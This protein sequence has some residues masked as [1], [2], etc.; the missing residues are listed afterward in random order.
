M[1]GVGR[2][3]CHIMLC[4]YCLSACMEHDVCHPLTPL[5]KRPLKNSQEGKAQI[6]PIYHTLGLFQPFLPQI[7]W[8]KCTRGMTQLHFSR[9]GRRV[10]AWGG[11]GRQA[12]QLH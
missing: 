11:Q 6:M 10:S 1:A 5:W 4:V 2:H 9:E 12:V 8:Q 3:P 7:Q